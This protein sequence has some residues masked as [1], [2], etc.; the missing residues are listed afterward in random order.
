MARKRRSR[1]NAHDYRLGELVMLMARVP[2]LEPGEIVQVV[3]FRNSKQLKLLPIGGLPV[4]AHFELVGRCGLPAGSE[5]PPHRR[6]FH[7]RN[8]KK[9]PL[10]RQ[11]RSDGKTAAAA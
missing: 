1:P 3:G 9:P 6:R 8:G 7:R 2:P 4:V 5:K 10:R 11:G